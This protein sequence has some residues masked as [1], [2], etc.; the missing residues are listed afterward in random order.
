MADIQEIRDDEIDL[1]ELFASLWAY[2]SVIGVITAGAI[3]AGGFYALNAEK[4]YTGSAVFQLEDSSRSGL[5]LPSEISGLAA[6]A[7]LGGVV[8]EGNTLFDRISGRAF[9]IDL[10]AAVDLKGDDYFN[11][12]DPTAED[13]LWKA[14][15][16][17]AIGYQSDDLDPE[18][19]VERNIVEAFRENVTVEETKNGSLSIK[20]DHTDPVRA[21]AIANAILDQVV[22]LTERDTEA[23]QGSQLSYLSETLAD[24]L[25]EMDDAQAR[26]KNFAIENSTLSFEALAAGSV[27]L[28]E[29]RNQLDRATALRDAANALLDA[30]DQGKADAEN[31]TQLRQSY[32]IIDDVEFRRVLGLSEI[33]SEF[34]WPDRQ[35]LGAVAAT[36][37][38]RRDR[39][40]REMGRLE[41][42]AIAY[43]NAAE[44][45]AALERDAKVAEASYT[46]LI[47]QVKAQSLLAGYRGETAKI[48]ERAVPP[49]VPSQPNRKLILA[50]AAVLGIFVGSGVALVLSLRKGV[51]FSKRALHDELQPTATVS[52]SR[53]RK[54]NGKNLQDAR[55]LLARIQNRSLSEIAITLRDHTKP[56]VVVLGGGAKCTARAAAFAVAVTVAG[57]GRRVAVVD[58]SRTGSAENPDD[59]EKG[60]WRELQSGDGVVELG[61]SGGRENIDLLASP[62]YAEAIKTVSDNY[63]LVLY[64]AETPLAE[65]CAAGLADLEPKAILVGRPKATAKALIHKLRGLKLPTILLLE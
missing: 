51:V 58:L 53:L 33:M 18:Q 45:Q 35:L 39:I 4:I 63:D 11:T 54:L 44:E 16:K 23:K 22:T 15:I 65:M 32:P 37:A 24:T 46:V 61:F 55:A 64:S 49:L 20:V 43:A 40:E 29:V 9:I 13:P 28:D 14:V 2:K 3:F 19:V 21:A 56:H 30:I 36:L 7:G 6:L 57:S 12:Y 25:R 62:K 52:A 34:S 8:N 26:L 47:E 59:T 41:T 60:L 10:D 31:Y 48:F 5:S 1:G 17:R 42:E 27:A 38:D 50:L